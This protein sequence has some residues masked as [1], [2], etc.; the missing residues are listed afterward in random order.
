[1]DEV[2]SHLLQLLASHETWRSQTI[3]LIASE[4]ALSPAVRGVLNSDLVQRYGD[5]SG[6]DLSARHYRGNR[7]IEQIEREAVR[8]A[9]ETFKAK[10]V[11]L[12]P[13]SGHVAGAAVLM[14]LCRP[15]DL[16]L[17]P[18]R[19]G[20]GHR[21]GA[22]FAASAMAPLEVNYLPID[23][24]RYNIDLER[25]AEQVQIRRPRVVILGSS[26]FLFPHPVEQVAGLL[27][28][29]SP[30]TVLVYDGSHVMGFLACGGFQNPLEE[31][32]G[33]VFGSTHKTL[34]GPQGGIIFSNRDDLMD[35]VCQA[36]Y[37]ALVTNHH[38]F[39][40]PAL[41]L[42]LLEMQ[43]WGPAY[44][45]QVIANAQALGAALEQKGVPC[46]GVDGVYTRSHTIL[47][48]VSKFGKGAEMAARLEAC[49]IITTAAHLPEYWGVEG[50]RLGT[51]EVTR[52]GA[53]S[54][55]MQQ[56]ASLIEQALSGSRSPEVI[57][58]DSAA[59]AA[60]LGPVRYTWMDEAK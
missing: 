4:N 54:D 10:Y 51:Q 23:P 59:F 47:A 20:G 43:Q 8:I 53:G 26:N 32:A 29:L 38:L 28:T 46:V 1:M 13:I 21:E 31:G 35:K 5:Y 56:I 6:R 48:C 11:E 30:E 9:Q 19:D 27:K 55:H 58:A 44:T 52:R 15:G 3:N 25:F 40:L 34:P 36:T 33:L 45:G 2:R 60:G 24:V 42:S 37:P 7:Y 18:G 12:R 14:G 17:E 57:C 16:V 41:A 22:K 39:R 50:L 49:G